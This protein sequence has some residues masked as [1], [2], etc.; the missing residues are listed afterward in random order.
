MKSSLAPRHGRLYQRMASDAAA[1]EPR[2]T[3]TAVNDSCFDLALTNAGHRVTA[4]FTPGAGRCNVTQPNSAHANRAASHQ[5]MSWR[6]VWSQR[7]S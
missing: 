4:R 7:P 2:P 5:A 1:L 3:W 6:P